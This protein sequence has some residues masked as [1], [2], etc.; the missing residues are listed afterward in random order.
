MLILGFVWL[1]LLVN[2]LIWNLSSA[3]EWLN[4]AIRI[5]FIHALREEISALREEIKSLTGK[6]AARSL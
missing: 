6:F 5:V 4:T 2:E 3:L 1:G